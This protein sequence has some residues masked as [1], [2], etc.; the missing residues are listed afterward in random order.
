MKNIVLW[1]EDN[2]YDSSLRFIFEEVKEH[3]LELHVARG[4]LD[5]KKKL[6]NIEIKDIKA[7]ILDV[8]LHRS[9]NSLD[10]FGHPEVILGRGEDTGYYLSKFIFRNKSG[11]FPEL[12]NIPILILTAKPIASLEDETIKGENNILLLPK[13]DRDTDW[14]GNVKSWIKKQAVQNAKK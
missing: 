7:I 1:I 5:L 8:M 6:D 2:P 11:D 13:N 14:E 9:T 10:A 3:N 4:V 12:A